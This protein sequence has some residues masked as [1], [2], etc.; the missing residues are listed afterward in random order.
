MNWNLD[1]IWAAETVKVDYH[2]SF[3]IC[4][5]LLTETGFNGIFVQRF[6]DTGIDMILCVGFSRGVFWAYDRSFEH[7]TLHQSLAV[8]HQAVL[9]P[10]RC[11]W[12][13]DDPGPDLGRRA[14]WQQSAMLPPDAAMRRPRNGR[15]R[16]RSANENQNK[17]ILAGVIDG[18]GTV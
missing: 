6:V 14:G 1:R 5:Q 17:A 15:S 4:A 12:G 13:G 3:S 10:A 7:G 18:A 11:P 2:F 8:A 9:A 16:S